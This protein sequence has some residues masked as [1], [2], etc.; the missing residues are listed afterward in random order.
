MKM[1]DILNNLKDLLDSL[2]SEAILHIPNLMLAIVIFLAGLLLAKIVRKLSKRVILYLHR[3]IND[4]LNTHRLSVDLQGSAGYIATAFFWVI[5]LFSIALITQI[6]EL[7]F[8]TKWFEGLINYLP[9]IIA[10]LVIVFSGY[11]AGKLTGD[12]VI[13]IAMRTAITNGRNLGGIAKYGI[14]SVSI[15]IAIDQLGIDI[16]F[17]TNLVLIILGALLF[18]AALAFGL[19][20]KTSVSNILSSYY[21][22]KAFEVGNFIQI[23]ETKGV[24]TKITSTSVTLDTESGQVII[25]AKDFNEKE[26]IKKV[27]YED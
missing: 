12:L 3:I 16:A 20:A 18:G 26:T 7:F 25:P 13:S 2:V 11:I 5:L 23:G 21:I 10:A 17:L 14:L 15:I 8:L 19:G 24:I 4:K 9:N 22:Q 27:S 1:N 6:L